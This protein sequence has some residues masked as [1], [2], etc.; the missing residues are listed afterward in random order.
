MSVI[1]LAFELE[2]DLIF[3]LADREWVFGLVISIK[4]PGVWVA[5]QAIVFE[6]N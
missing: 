2:V 5:V 4:R 3:G 1:E 6:V